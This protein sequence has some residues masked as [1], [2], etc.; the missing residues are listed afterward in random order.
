MM[1]APV[2]RNDA[3]LVTFGVPPRLLSSGRAA[4]LRYFPKAPFKWDYV[5]F[6]SQETLTPTDG[7]LLI[8]GYC[9]RSG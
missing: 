4:P 7:V 9:P 2:R 5:L 1:I 3:G 6:P 8:L